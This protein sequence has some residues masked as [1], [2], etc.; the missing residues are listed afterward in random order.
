[1]C[2]IALHLHS[3]HMTARPLA[4]SCA[5]PACRPGSCTSGQCTAPWA[6]PCSTSM[7]VLKPP[8]TGGEQ[9][10]CRRPRVHGCGAFAAQQQHIC[11]YAQLDHQ[12]ACMHPKTSL[13]SMCLH[14]CMMVVSLHQLSAGEPNCV[15]C[16][17]T[18]SN[19]EGTAG[20]Q[21]ALRQPS[22]RLRQRFLPQPHG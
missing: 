1:M 5:A 4:K 8:G 22:Q 9:T 3:C 12:H 10:L 6:C 18:T 17:R 21:A 15:A 11:M 16:S 20:S 14:A 19:W 2:S 7:E 13:G